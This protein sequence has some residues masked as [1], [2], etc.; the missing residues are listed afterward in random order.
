MRRNVLRSLAA[1]LGGAAIYWALMRYLP[2]PL[3]HHVD[4]IDLG[5]LTYALISLALLL[6]L[7]WM[8]RA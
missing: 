1:V 4:R 7:L 2:A 3:Q 8:E 6:L 5:L